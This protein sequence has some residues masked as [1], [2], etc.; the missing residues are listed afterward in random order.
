MPD[1][2]KLVRERL[3]G[4]ALEPQER[5]E[6]I[7]ELAAHLE[8]SYEFLL[9]SGCTEREAA[10]RT[11]AEVPN[12][13]K[14]WKG[15]Q[16]AR[17]KEQG[18]TD[19]VKQLWLP[20]LF[21]MLSSMGL[22]MLIEFLGPSPQLSARKN[23]WALI[24]PAAVIY[25]PWLLSLP[26]V[27]AVGAYLGKRA[28]ASQRVMF[29]AVLFPVLPYL[30][31]FFIGL[32]LIVAL[33]D[34][35]KDNVMFGIFFVGFYAWVLAPGVALLAGALLAQLILSRCSPNGSLTAR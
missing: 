26:L 4:L 35:L 20:S 5:R 21:S 27:G 25:I 1:W 24:A 12:W 17:P 10:Q 29:S 15:I 8:D 23:G 6:I 22:L 34:H 31:F 30:V 32:P 28:R 18:M 14:L 9:K 33:N 11:L 13:R 19:R 3:Q 7:E 2:Q 16:R